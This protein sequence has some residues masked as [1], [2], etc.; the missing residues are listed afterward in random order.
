M[1]ARERKGTTLPLTATPSD[2]AMD[3]STTGMLAPAIS[4]GSFSSLS[5]SANVVGAAWVLSSAIFTTYSTTTFLKFQGPEVIKRGGSALSALSRPG[6]LTLYR[7]GGSLL[8]GIIAHPNF[9][10]GK[11]VEDTLQNLPAF[12]L[13]AIF[14]FVANYANSIALNRIGISLTYTS[15]CAIPLITVLLTLILDGKSALPSK[16]TLLSLIPIALG[17]ACASWN[18]PTFEAFGFASSNDIMLLLR[19]P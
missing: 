2:T 15:K 4:P 10:L 13:P 18:S 8:L 5:Q 11:R 3:P 6:L 17:I 12:T 1:R 16:E 9:N 19:V 7:F 14:L